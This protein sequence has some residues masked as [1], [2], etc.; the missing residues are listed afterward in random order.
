MKADI[1]SVRVERGHEFL[2]QRV[3]QEI[4]TFTIEMKP[5]DGK[6]L[7]VAPDGTIGGWSLKDLREVIQRPSEFVRLELPE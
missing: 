5:K 7:V 1:T 4:L 6:Q 2:G 3:D